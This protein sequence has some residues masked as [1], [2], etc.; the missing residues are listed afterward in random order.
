[1]LTIITYA[2]LLFKTLPL[3]HTKNVQIVHFTCPAIDRPHSGSDDQKAERGNRISGRRDEHQK[4]SKQFHKNPDAD[5]PPVIQLYG[6]ES[7]NQTPQHQAAENQRNKGRDRLRTDF[8]VNAC[9]VTGCPEKAGRF[10]GTVC[11]KRRR[12]QHD[13]AAADGIYN[14]DETSFYRTAKPKKVRNGVPDSDLFHFKNEGAK[15]ITEICPCFSCGKYYLTGSAP[16][17]IM[18]TK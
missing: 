3:I 7:G 18:I 16:V 4:D 12:R 17:L 13:E 6:N 9:K 15:K 1:M 8:P 2:I 11:K 5:Q 10:S 14:Q